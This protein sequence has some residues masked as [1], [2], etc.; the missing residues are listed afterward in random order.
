VFAPIFYVIV[1]PTF[2]LCLSCLLHFCGRRFF[3][4]F[5]G[6]LMDNFLACDAHPGFTSHH[7]HHIVPQESHDHRH[8]IASQASHRI[9]VTISHHRFHIASQTPHHITGI[10]S[11]HRHHIASQSHMITDI[12]SQSHRSQTSQS[13]HRVTDHRHHITGFTS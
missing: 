12:T 9:T 13:H 10:T 2:D 5:L 11:H 4:R 6:F 8:H 1:F 3:S 7:R